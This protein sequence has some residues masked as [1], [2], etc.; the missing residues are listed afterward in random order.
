M[1][2]QEEHCGQQNAGNPKAATNR[3]WDPFSEINK[4]FHSCCRKWLG[5]INS[6]E[7]Q[8]QVSLDHFTGVLLKFQSNSVESLMKIHVL[9]EDGVGQLSSLQATWLFCI[10]HPIFFTL[11]NGGLLR[12]WYVPAK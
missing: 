7:T 1:N 2:V 8:S 6:R 9:V 10:S 5:D 3:K 12:E 4:R 11:D